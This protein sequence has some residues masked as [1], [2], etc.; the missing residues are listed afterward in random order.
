MFL[1]TTGKVN[2]MAARPRTRPAFVADLKPHD[3]LKLLSWLDPLDSSSFTIKERDGNAARLLQ[4][5]EQLRKTV[6][7]K[8][9]LQ[10]HLDKVKRHAAA[11]EYNSR[12]KARAQEEATRAKEIRT[13]TKQ[14]RD[15]YAVTVGMKP[16]FHTPSGSRSSTPSSSP[17]NTPQGT[18]DSTPS[19][20]PEGTPNPSPS[21]S[22]Q[23]RRPDST[24][25]MWPPS[26]AQPE[27]NA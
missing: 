15:Y 19:S 16:H 10:K 24:G 26:E 18:P 2:T 14:A 6:Q 7:S 27:L 1:D 8:V 25:A 9:E 21:N 4:Q 13:A 17:G 11:Q 23:A 20:S 5:R 22:P 3:R 12:M